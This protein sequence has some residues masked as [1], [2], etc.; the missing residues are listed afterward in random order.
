MYDGEIFF[1]VHTT[2]IQKIHSNLSVIQQ[3]TQKN[4]TNNNTKTNS[5]SISI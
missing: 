4:T 5:N 3:S 2:V 1:T